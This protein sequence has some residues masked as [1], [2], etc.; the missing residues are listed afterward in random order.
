MGTLAA[1][2]LVNTDITEKP[3]TAYILLYSQNGC[4][5]TCTFCPQSV[6][7]TSSKSL[8]SR[9][10]WPEVNLDIL[11]ERINSTSVFKRICIQTVIKRGFEDEVVE[12][13]NTLRNKGVEIPI[14]I[15]LTPVNKN[16]IMLLKDLKVDS[17][18]IGID[19]ATPKTLNLVKKPYSWQEY[20]QFLEN[21]ID[22][23]GSSKTY[24]HL[25]YG[26]GD[27]DVEFYNAMKYFTKLGI[28]IALF[29]FTPIKGTLSEFWKRPNVI[30][31]RKMQ[32]LRY[33]L[34][35]GCNVDEHI[36]IRNGSIYLR[37][38]LIKDVLEN[39]SEY[40]GAFIT[41]GCPGCNRPFYNESVRG[42]YYNYPSV[43]FL[44]K[45]LSELLEELKIIMSEAEYIEKY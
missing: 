26:L 30:S 2:R 18:G 27:S 38:E 7:S 28:G 3:T 11:I 23:F 17:I 12:I 1:V 36:I 5:G 4:L 40:L 45:H 19:A 31:Y 10:S 20:M 21:C 44:L 22:V 32:L 13:I 25:I 35:L 15:S 37:K 16:Y 41:S 24:V 29:A 43:N 34:T 9:V 6:L 39:I 14:S 33:L 8:V 42:P